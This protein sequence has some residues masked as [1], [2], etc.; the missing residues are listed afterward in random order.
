VIGDA[1]D[2]AAAA[3]DPD[4]SFIALLADWG[5]PFLLIYAVVHPLGK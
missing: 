2:E 5:R 1:E 4:Q 3:F